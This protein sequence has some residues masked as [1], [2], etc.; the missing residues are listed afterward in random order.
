M[1]K[2]RFVG[3]ISKFYNELYILN[4]AIGFIKGSGAAPR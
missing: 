4:N 3:G 2:E 1:I